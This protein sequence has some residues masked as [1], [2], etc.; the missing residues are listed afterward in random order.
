[1]MPHPYYTPLASFT[2]GPHRRVCMR[3]LPL[4]FSTTASDNP[5]TQAY[6]LSNF[7]YSLPPTSPRVSALHEASGIQGSGA[8][9]LSWGG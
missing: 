3:T 1:M 6:W 4:L 7:P 9:Q 8:L 5:L 2:C